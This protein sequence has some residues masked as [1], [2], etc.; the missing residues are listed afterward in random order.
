MKDRVERARTQIITVS[1]KL[2]NHLQSVD[3]PFGSVRQQVNA[4]EGQENVA[5]YIG[6]RYRLPKQLTTGRRTRMRRGSPDSSQSI[7]AAPRA[8]TKRPPLNSRRPADP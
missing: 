7:K 5:K 1:R 8:R 6:H 4:D 2:L 3:R